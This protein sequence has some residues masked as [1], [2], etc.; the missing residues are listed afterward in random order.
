MS[1]QYEK[2]KAKEKKV[3]EPAREPTYDRVAFDVYK[4]EKTR[5]YMKVTLEY[6]LESGIGRV[7]DVKVIADSQPLAVMKMNESIARKIF[8]IK[9][10]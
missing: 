6:D 2:R 5:K 10:E 7:R 9:G 8:N 1:S 3:L 4:D